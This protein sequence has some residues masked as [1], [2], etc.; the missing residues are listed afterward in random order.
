[1]YVV[2]DETAA[3]GPERKETLRA[4]N[5]GERFLAQRGFVYSREFC[6][7]TRT[8]GSAH[9]GY[10]V[11][12]LIAVVVVLGARELGRSGLQQGSALPFPLFFSLPA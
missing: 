3:R 11:Q 10:S 8:V 7:T 9:E 1:M 2:L 12:L 5:L 6:V 4:E